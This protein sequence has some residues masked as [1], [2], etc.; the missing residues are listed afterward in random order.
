MI[1]TMNIHDARLSLGRF[2]LLT[3]TTYTVTLKTGDGG[4]TIKLFLNKD[5]WQRLQPVI[6]A[7]VA[8]EKINP[9]PALAAGAEYA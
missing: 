5:E 2:G 9:Q 6:S 4:P 7:L 1:T 3:E 8:A